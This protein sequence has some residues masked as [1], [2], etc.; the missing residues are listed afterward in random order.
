MYF[1]QR[2]I[3][4]S[5]IRKQHFLLF[6]H[7]FRSQPSDEVVNT[8]DCCPCV[9]HHHGFPLTPSRPV[10]SWCWYRDPGWV[11]TSL[12]YLLNSRPDCWT[13]QWNYSYYN[14]PIIWIKLNILSKLSN[15]YAPIFT[16]KNQWFFYSTCRL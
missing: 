14:S 9:W 4:W 2:L 15:S 16:N 11:S 3:I 1:N 6:G 5:S 7:R 10:T 13:K 12:S 8:I